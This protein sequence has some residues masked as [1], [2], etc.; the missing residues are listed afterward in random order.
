MGSKHILREVTPSKPPDEPQRQGPHNQKKVAS[1][2]DLSATGW[3][4]MMNT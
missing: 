2:T 1:S 3:T 4:V